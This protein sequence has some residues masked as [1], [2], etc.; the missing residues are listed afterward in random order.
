MVVLLPVAPPLLAA[1]GSDY[2]STAQLAAC[3]QEL[4]KLTGEGYTCA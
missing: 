4:A 2:D 1:D 3:K